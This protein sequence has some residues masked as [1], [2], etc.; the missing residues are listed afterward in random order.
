MATTSKEGS[1]RVNYPIPIRGDSDKK[2]LCRAQWV[3]LWEWVQFKNISEEP[4]EGKS[5]LGARNK[6]KK[7]PF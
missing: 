5:G 7:A 1:R 3:L 2:Y 6:G 4:L